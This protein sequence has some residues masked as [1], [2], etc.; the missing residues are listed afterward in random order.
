MSFT[1]IT[2]G[3]IDHG[4]TALV[5]A[6]TG[7]DADRLPEEKRRGITIEAGFAPFCEG[8]AEGVF[9][10]VPGHE[11]LLHNM[12]AAAGCFDAVL[13]CVDVAEGVMPQTREHMQVLSLLGAKRGIAVLT[14]CDKATPIEIAEAK[15]ALADF[16]QGGFMQNAPIFAVSVRTAQGMDALKQAIFAMAKADTPRKNAIDTPFFMPIDR[17]FTKSGFGTVVTGAALCGH[18]CAGDVLT[19]YPSQK[20]V[21]VRGLAHSGQAAA[22][23]YAGQRLSL[24]VP[25]LATHEIERG[26][27]L[28]AVKGLCFQRAFGARITVPKE[29]VPL[30]NGKELQLCIGTAHTLCRVTLYGELAYIRTTDLLAVRGGQ[31]FL[32]RSLSPCATIGGGEVLSPLCENETRFDKREKARLTAYQAGID[33]AIFYE[34]SRRALSASAIQTLFF[35]EAPAVIHAALARLLAQGQIV[36]SG[37]VY[38]HA[39]G[40]APAAS[41]HTDALCAFYLAAAQTPPNLYEAA[42]ALHIPLHLAQHAANALCEGGTLICLLQGL[43]MHRTAYDAILLAAKDLIAAEGGVTV[44]SLRDK[45]GLSR[46]YTRAVLEHGDANGVF[47][48]TDTVR[49][50]QN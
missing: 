23:G 5:K 45:T 46:K 21:T 28:C 15:R 34:L 27:V 8:D 25:Q 9:V 44:A 4:K 41:A 19:L 6:I 12:A 38:R 11:K 39:Q 35:F 20:S 22:M 48:N 43:Y 7:I 31:R 40:T 50:L 42:K 24:N 16:L 29:H 17:V 13:L 26:A 33:S 10:D 14:K 30:I 18:I 49:T 36:N 32:L 3:H 47:I 1:I 37:G 2:A